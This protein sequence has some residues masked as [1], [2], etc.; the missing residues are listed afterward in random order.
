MLAGTIRENLLLGAPDA[1]DEDCEAV[2]A[3]VNLDGVLRRDPAGLGAQVGEDGILLSGGERQRLA[4][5]RALLASPDGAAAGRAD[6]QPGRPERAGAAGGDR[7][8][9]PRPDADPGRAP[10]GHRR[11]RRP[12]PG[13]G[14]RPAAGR[15][16]PPRA[17]ARP[18][19]CTGSWPSTSCWPESRTG[20]TVGRAARRT[21]QTAAAA[22]RPAIRPENRQ[23]P[24]NEPSSAR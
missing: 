11:R 10:A 19:R 14:G 8:H 17:A 20:R 12:D 13:A 16:H 21:D 7:R 4:I 5:A 1:T 2:L 23:P 18:A 15:R 9:L 24:R 3:A 6:R 22:A